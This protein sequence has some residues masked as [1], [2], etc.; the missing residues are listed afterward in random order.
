MRRIS[1]PKKRVNSYTR[2]EGRGKTGPEMSDLGVNRR[3]GAVSFKE[4][5]GGGEMRVRGVSDVSGS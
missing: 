4:L 2:P 5:L 1:T 3:E